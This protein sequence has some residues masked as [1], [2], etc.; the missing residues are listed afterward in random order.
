[1]GTGMGESSFVTPETRGTFLILPGTPSL[2]RPLDWVRVCD[3]IERVMFISPLKDSGPPAGRR[4][5]SPDAPR[6]RARS[7]VPSHGASTCPRTVIPRA[8]ARSFRVLSHG[9]SCPRTVRRGT[10]RT[11]EE[12]LNKRSAS[13]NDFDDEEEQGGFDKGVDD[14]PLTL[15]N[16]WSH[17]G[18]YTCV[19]LSHIHV[20][21]LLLSWRPD[22]ALA[23]EINYLGVSSCMAQIKSIATQPRIMETLI[24]SS[25]LP[26]C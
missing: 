17:Q 11:A 6:A 19:L 16:P 20:S 10:A 25:S 22:G 1:M 21:G 8:L 26:G 18:T 3:D 2:S 24:F 12:A 13:S 5:R 14:S 9:S 7:H 4:L 15:A 23:L